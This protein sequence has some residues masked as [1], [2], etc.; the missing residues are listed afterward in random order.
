M[1]HDLCDGVRQPEERGEELPD[2]RT[3]L[4]PEAAMDPTCRST[5]NASGKTTAGAAGRNVSQANRAVMR[6]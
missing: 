4:S 5:F 2:F 3:A 6:G 1:M